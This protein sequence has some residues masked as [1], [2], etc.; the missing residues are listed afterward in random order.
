MIVAKAQEEPRHS[1]GCVERLPMAGRFGRY[2]KEEGQDVRANPTKP[3]AVQEALRNIW[4]TTSVCMT[5][6]SHDYL[7]DLLRSRFIPENQRVIEK[8]Y[9]H[10]SHKQFDRIISNLDGRVLS[11]QDISEFTL[12]LNE[13]EGCR[14]FS[15]KSG[16]FLSALIHASPEGEYHIFTDHWVIKPDLIGYRNR[17]GH[18]V[19]VHGDVGTDCGCQMV[20]G[21]IIVD[22]MASWG[23]G[24]L[25]EGGSITVS[26]CSAQFIGM[27]S[28]GGTIHI[29]EGDPQ[30]F[31]EDVA[32]ASKYGSK[33]SIYH[34]D[35]L[36]FGDEGE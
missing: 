19:I 32:A 16:L 25:M 34:K 8:K 36:I 24:V 28:K 29:R 2:S 5:S 26:D 22:G 31:R 18:R 21:E 10:P 4:E 7:M 27:A 11:P 15:G 30:T 35:K 14:G 33:T 6:A 20:G 12:S 9:R 1:A 17:A 13:S 23:L 3:S